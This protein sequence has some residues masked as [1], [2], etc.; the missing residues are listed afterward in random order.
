MFKDKHVYGGKG[1]V[2][3]ATIHGFF[4]WI[5]LVFFVP[6]IALILAALDGVAHYHID[7]LK[8]GWNF[9]TKATPAENRFWYA[10]GLDQLAHMLTYVLMVLIA[11]RW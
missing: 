3:H 6:E 2:V 7:Y 1:G 4:S 8:S 5:I 9:R 10:F 11:T